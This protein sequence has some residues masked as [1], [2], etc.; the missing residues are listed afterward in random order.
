VQTSATAKIDFLPGRLGRLIGRKPQT[1]SIHVSLPTAHM[2]PPDFTLMPS[3]YC[4]E[5]INDNLILRARSHIKWENFP[6]NV[7]FL[8]MAL[9]HPAKLQACLIGI[10]RRSSGSFES[11]LSS[12]VRCRDWESAD[13]IFEAYKGKKLVGWTAPFTLKLPKSS[14]PSAENVKPQDLRAKLRTITHKK[15]DRAHEIS[16]GLAPLTFRFNILDVPKDMNMLYLDLTMQPKTGVQS[17]LQVHQF[18]VSARYEN[19]GNISFTL[20][21]PHYVLALLNS[22][23]EINKIECET[24]LTAKKDGLPFEGTPLKMKFGLVE[25]YNRTKTEEEK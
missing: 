16:L 6:K 2:T 12:D 25:Y 13:F 10:G 18:H 23:E 1:G 24:V 7:D 14:L 4:P 21:F 15:A 22:P 11:L 3:Y 19:S 5:G 9:N 8:R 20:A 17:G